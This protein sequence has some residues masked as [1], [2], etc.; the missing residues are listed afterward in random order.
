MAGAI[1]TAL[2][3]HAAATPLATALQGD[4]DTLDYATLVQRI[5]ELA[6]WLREHGVHRAALCGGN[7]PSWLVADLAAW[8][9]GVVLVPVPPFFSPGQREYVLRAAGIDHLLCC[10]EEQ[11]PVD[12]GEI[13]DAPLPDL[14]PVRLTDAPISI[15]L[16]HGT[17]KITFTSG[18]TGQPKGVCLD[19][20]MLDAVAGALVARIHQAPGMVEAVQAHFTL[21]PLATLLEN[22]AGAYVPLLLGKR[23][24]VRGETQTGL[25]GSSGLDLP[26]LLQTLH[27]DQPQSLIVLPQILRA[28]VLAAEQ[29]ATPPASLR[30]VAVG[31]ATTPPALIAR[32]RDLG[33]PVYEGYG[34]SECGSVVA[35]NAPGDD[36]VGSVGRVLPHVRVRVKGDAIQVAGNVFP[37]YLGQSA[38][39]REDWL[40]TGDLGR[41]DDD[42]FV[43]VTGRRKHLLITGYG[44]NVSPEWVEAE[45]SLSPA[46]AQA[47]VVGE[48]QAFLGAIVVPARGATPDTVA[49]AISEANAR[50]PDYAR[51]RRFLL[52]DEPFT[53][54]SGTLTDNGRLRRD[55]IAARYADRLAAL[56]APVSPAPLPEPAHEVL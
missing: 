37:G 32:A 33:L 51:A 44:R 25:L 5:D 3:A 7:S 2:R 13:I 9:A 1:L 43:Y 47:M 14:R 56:F 8:Q 11:F 50:L 55:A 28:L 20:A 54:A 26:R 27:R 31:G 17:C 12:C 24:I 53:T 30:F 49:S 40:D 41:M 21:L 6:T 34:L 16:P 15:A 10:G 29:G 48:A 45:L 4:R 36:R 22:V 52:A 38:S 19:G 42:G 46:I 23:V 39:T 35:L 18:T